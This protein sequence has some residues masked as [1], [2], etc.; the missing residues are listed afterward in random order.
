MLSTDISGLGVLVCHSSPKD[1]NHKPGSGPSAN[2]YSLQFESSALRRISMQFR[3]TTLR[4]F[5]GSTLHPYKAICNPRKRGSARPTWLS[6]VAQ[7]QD[8]RAAF[9]RYEHFSLK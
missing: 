8:S 9:F 7:D 5:D 6:E 2:D 3:K 1:T 4:E